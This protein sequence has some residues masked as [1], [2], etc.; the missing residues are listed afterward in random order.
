MH[1]SRTR[2]MAISG[3]ALAIVL[4]STA[5]VTANHG[6][7]DARAFGFG[8]RMEG[9]SRDR[10]EGRLRLRGMGLRG[11]PAG[12]VRS[13]T[14]FQSGDG[15]VTQRV[16]NGT[17]S[18]ASDGSLDYDLANGEVA[19][20]SVDDQTSVVGFTRQTIER[21]GWTRDRW[22]PQAVA[23]ADVTAGSEVTVWSRSQ[24]DGSYLAQ[25]I[26][27]RPTIEPTTE[28]SP[29]TPLEGETEPVAPVEPEESAVPAA[30]AA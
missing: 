19:T 29:E 8:P 16:D 21:R 20:V 17:V 7:D 26:V 25:R 15:F 27:V 13:E 12:L 30:A 2:L 5:V 14:T 3:T 18:V 24:D 10:G 11:A 9:P 1:T 6:R 28:E 4:A 23:L 22:A